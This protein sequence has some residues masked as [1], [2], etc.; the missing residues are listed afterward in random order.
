MADHKYLIKYKAKSDVFKSE[1]HSSLQQDSVNCTGPGSV[2]VAYFWFTTI[3]RTYA[4]E[5]LDPVLLNLY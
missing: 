3:I 2:R 4:I 1:K 5:K